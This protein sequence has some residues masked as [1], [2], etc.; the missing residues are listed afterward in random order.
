MWR[1]RRIASSL[2]PMLPSHRHGRRLGAAVL[3]AAAVAL[4]EPATGLAHRA[5]HVKAPKRGQ[6]I[7]ETRQDREFT[8]Y[9][10][11]HRRVSRVELQFDCGYA[12]GRGVVRHLKLHRTKRGYRFSFK[13]RRRVS[14]ADRSP[15]QRALIAISGRFAR[16]GTKARGRVRV[17][18]RHC[19]GSGKV[20]WFAKRTSTPVRTPKSGSYAGK[21]GQGRDLGLYTSG[22][23]IQLADIQFSCGDAVG[24]TSLNGIPLRRTRKGYAFDIAA[25]GNVTYSDDYPDE[26]AA[27]SISGRFNPAGRKAAGR[28]TVK[29][30]RCGST[31]RVGWSVK[32]A[33]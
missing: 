32:R 8:L 9:V 1:V 11:R 30:P 18:S 25:H 10:A 3:I 5:A 2:D 31:G 22:R 33:G 27:V 26:N 29:S 4:V 12:S 6:Y 15:G 17:K 7:G 21:T 14:Y 13:G 16:T 28:L 23:S 20:R 19:G 24:R